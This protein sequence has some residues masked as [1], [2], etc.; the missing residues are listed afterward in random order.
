MEHVQGRIFRHN[1]ITEV[2]PE[3]RCALNVAVT[4]T[5]AWLHSLD[6]NELAL[7]GHDS[8]EGY[9]KREILAWKELHEESCHMDIPSMN[10]LSSWLL[11]NLPTTDEEP[12]L[13]H[14]DFRIPNVIFHPT[15]VGITS[16]K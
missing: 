9:C 2:S 16:S 1:I 13:L 3:E 6:L 14:G 15:E 5:L 4:E 12:K 11:N 7:P 8:R 10:E